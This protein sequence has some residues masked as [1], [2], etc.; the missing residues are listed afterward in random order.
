MEDLT[1]AAHKLDELIAL[2]R[3][4]TGLD[5]DARIHRRDIVP[6]PE[7]PPHPELTVDFSGPDS[8]LLLERQGEL[9]HAQ[10]NRIWKL[11][12]L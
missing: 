4:S 1:D 5:L 12:R 7:T 8:H 2:L 6:H 10:G 3:N 9:L 11:N